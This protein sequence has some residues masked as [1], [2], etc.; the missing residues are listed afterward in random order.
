MFFFYTLCSDYSP[1]SWLEWKKHVLAQK[2][3][4][5]DRQS[6]KRR[7]EDQLLIELKYSLDQDTTSTAGKPVVTVIKKDETMTRKAVQPVVKTTMWHMI[8]SLI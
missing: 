3:S 2:H 6:T 8:I 7:Q 1:A 4:V 5:E